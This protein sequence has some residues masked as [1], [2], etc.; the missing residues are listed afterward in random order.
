MVVGVK[1]LIFTACPPS[2]ARSAI[3]DKTEDWILG[4]L[5]DLAEPYPDLLDD[6]PG[7]AKA[8]C[9][10]GYKTFASLAFMHP[11]FSGASGD[12][13]AEV[14]KALK[15][16][17]VLA[18]AIVA[19]GIALHPRD[20]V[21]SGA[22]SRSRS[23]PP[24]GPRRRSRSRS[25]PPQERRWQAYSDKLN[26]G[27]TILETEL[28]RFMESLLLF[29]YGQSDELGAIL[30]KFGQDP[31]MSDTDFD[32]LNAQVPERL[33]RQLAA[34]LMPALPTQMGQALSAKLKPGVYGLVLLRAVCA[35]HYGPIAIKAKLLTAANLCYNDVVPVTQKCELRERLNAHLRALQFLEDAHQN[36]GDA[37]TGVGLLKLV[38]QLQL[39]P[40]IDAARNIH[41]RNSL[42]WESKDLLELL[43]KRANEWLLLPPSGKH[44]V[45]AAGPSAGPSTGHV[46]NCHKWMNG[47]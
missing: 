35:H 44:V 2:P 15:I 45:A 13:V 5:T 22:R 30:H 39:Q 25:P 23:P 28:K 10:L 16:N 37:M 18:K 19:E 24:P 34:A 33:Q 32:L 9:K 29:V 8:L 20:E 40:E 11:E 31:G 42:V 26:G 43:E 14:Q 12:S 46:A 41:E 4:W 36:M 27:H 7:Y 3:N 6:L 17:V 38:S 21:R 47:R 1:R